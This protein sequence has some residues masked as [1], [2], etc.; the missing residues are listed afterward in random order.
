MEESIS[1]IMPVYNAAKYLDK[2]IGSVLGQS[3]RNLELIVVDDGSRDGSIGIIR[4][5]M[6][7][8]SR[9]VLMAQE[10]GGVSAARNAGLR[11]ARGNY[12]AF[13]DADDY[14]EPD[15]YRSMLLG[16]PKGMDVYWE[17]LKKLY[18]TGMLEMELPWKEG[19][20]TPEQ[21]RATIIPQMLAVKPGEAK[22]IIMGS[23]CCVLLKKELITDHQIEFD[24]QLKIAEDLM[25]M[26]ETFLYASSLYLVPNYG[27]VYVRHPGTALQR[28]RESCIEENITYLQK[29]RALLERFHLLSERSLRERFCAAKFILYMRVISNFY[30]ADAP[31]K[32]RLRNVKRVVRLIREDTDMPG[33]NLEYL[34]KGRRLVYFLALHHSS[35]SIWVLYQ[36]RAALQKKKSLHP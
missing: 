34:G 5:Y 14:L 3:H 16:H 30:R 8:D 19:M 25:F 18:S 9:I 24:I 33:L 29:Q 10:H 1:V 31:R 23:A 6:A 13:I 7:K 35:W 26:L 21:I 32:G 4:Q 2:S 20:Y 17:G 28:Y 11:K 36:L 27:Y 12:I 15:Y 22:E